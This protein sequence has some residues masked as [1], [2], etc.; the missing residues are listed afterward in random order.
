MRLAIS[1]IAWD[2]HEDIAV[3]KLMGKFGIDAIDIVPGKYFPDPFNVNDKDLANVRRWWADQGIEITG[4]Q[5]LLF[6]STGL[7]IFGD[8]KSQ[9]KMLEYLQAVCRIGSGLGASKLVFGSPKNR[10]R[11]GLND[12]QTLDRAFSFFQ[13]LGN[14]A[15][16]YGVIICIEPNPTRYGANFMTTSE[17]TADIVK[18]VDHVAIKMLFDTGSITINK[19]SPQSVLSSYAGLIRHVHVSEPNLLPLGDGETDHLA[20]YKA[21]QKYLPRHLVSI[22]MLATKEEP[23]LKSI[24]RA[25]AYAVN[26]YSATSPGATK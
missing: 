22:E 23:H 1:N 19:E 10:D 3:A 18:A 20:M 9:K 21:L 11:S 6:N 26:V 17:E 16:E 8:K 4:M 25:L 24:E 12:D 2:I 13:Y 5:S 14:T 15:K 7:N